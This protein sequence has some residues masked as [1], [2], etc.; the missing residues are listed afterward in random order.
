MKTIKL[1]NSNLTGTN[2]NRGVLIKAIS[3]NMPFQRARIKNRFIA[4]LMAKQNE[5]NENRVTI[6]NEICEKDADNKPILESGQYK[7]SDENS[8]KFQEEFQKL[9]EED[10][11]IDVAPSME[12]DI[13]DIKS[14]IHA[15][16]V[17]LNEVETAQ[18]E[19]ILTAMDAMNPEKKVVKAKTEDK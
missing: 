10:C 16:P 15:S 17:E 7:L 12:K 8:K 9:M 11:I 18:L 2:T 14:M 19:E 4:V 1:K 6:L 5:I 13:S 3:Y